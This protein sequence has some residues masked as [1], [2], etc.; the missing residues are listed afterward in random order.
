M[1]I[2]PEGAAAVRAAKIIRERGI[3]GPDDPVL[4]LNTGAG[5]KYTE[6][7]TEKA[8]KATEI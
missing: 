1:L 6:L 7:L 8:R 4:I 2:C 5:S 3:V